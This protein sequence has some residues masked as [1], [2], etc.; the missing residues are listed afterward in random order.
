MVYLGLEPG[1]QIEGADKSTELWWYP[2]FVYAASSCIEKGLTKICFCAISSCRRLFG[3][4]Q[5]FHHFK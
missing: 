2:K 4:F 5:I 1:W 3:V